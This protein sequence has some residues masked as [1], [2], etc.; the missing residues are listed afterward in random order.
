MKKKILS[1]LIPSRGRVEILTQSIYN[2]I[3]SFKQNIDDVEIIINLDLDDLESHKILSNQFDVEIK[4][5]ISDRLKGY[6]SLSDFMSQCYKLSEGY[7]FVLYNDDIRIKNNHG[8]IENLKEVKD[9]ISISSETLT[10]HI[11]IIHHKIIEITNGFHS[12]VVYYDGH[13]C[14]VKLSLPIENQF[15]FKIDYDHQNLWFSTIYDEK[16][17]TVK[18]Y[19]F[20]I[21]LGHGERYFVDLDSNAIKNF[22]NN[23]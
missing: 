23:Y 6:L 15:N 20:D 3:E 14:N 17:E 9:I 7:F 2:I 5:I 16:N 11:P 4:Y 22:F 21:S 13:Y 18:D 10:S 19:G 8:L 1:F 12:E